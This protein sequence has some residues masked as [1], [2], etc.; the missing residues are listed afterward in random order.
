VNVVVATSLLAV[1][2]AGCSRVPVPEA[3]VAAPKH[4][5]PVVIRRTVVIQATES[6]VLGVKPGSRAA[7]ALK[8]FRTEEK[9]A[10]A[11]RSYPGATAEQLRV[12]NET[13]RA[14]HAATQNLINKDGHFTSDDEKSAHDAID[15]L[16]NARQAPTEDK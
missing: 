7:R 11:A 14:A 12:I 13:E 1:V 15:N 4:A 6:E 2:I 16:H 5:A 8:A 10:S 3:V 9:A